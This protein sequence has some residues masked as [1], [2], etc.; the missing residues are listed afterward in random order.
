MI[1]LQR[2]QGAHDTSSNKQTGDVRAECF[3][4]ELWMWAVSV[5]TSRSVNHGKELAI[6]LGGDVFNHWRQPSHKVARSMRDRYRQIDLSLTTD[7]Y[8]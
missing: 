4:F 3:S 8:G 6:P 1:F 7:W 5:V 2:L